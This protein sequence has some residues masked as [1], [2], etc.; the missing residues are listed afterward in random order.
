MCLEQR[1]ENEDHRLPLPALGRGLSQLGW[2]R[3]CFLDN[4]ELT[5]TPTHEGGRVPWPAL[6][7]SRG[8]APGLPR[9]EGVVYLP[10]VGKQLK[11]ASKLVPYMCVAGK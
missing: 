7:L 11:M 1:R 5:W 6:R 3:G 2:P 9:R 10:T 8:R 4:P